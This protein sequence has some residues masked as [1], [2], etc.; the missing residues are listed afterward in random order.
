MK[1]ILL[2]GRSGGPGTP[3]GRLINRR[4]HRWYENIVLSL[5]LLSF[6]PSLFGWG[7]R[8]LDVGQGL[9][10]AEFREDRVLKHPMHLL[11]LPLDSLLSLLE[12][13]FSL[14]FCRCIGKGRRL[15]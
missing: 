13:K 10:L 11:F 8:W 7:L 2:L 3:V 1:L 4:P 6:P 9:P 5:F 12:F 15:T 14:F